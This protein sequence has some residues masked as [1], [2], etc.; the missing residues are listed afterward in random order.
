M[1][2]TEFIEAVAEKADISKA[3]AQRTVNAM[4]DVITE[5]LASGDRIVL[6]GFGSFEVRETKKRQGV[7]PR[8]KQKIVI[9]ASKRPSFSAGASLKQA[10][11]YAG[12]GGPPGDLMTSPSIHRGD[13]IIRPRIPKSSEKPE[14][15]SQPK[16]SSE[17]PEG[18]PRPKRPNKPI[19]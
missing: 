17:K 2:K 16:P 8:T 7:N 1:N 11:A 12:T 10:T 14:S 4:L 3:E 15:D 6:T 5:T 19:N 9:P 13:P 18:D